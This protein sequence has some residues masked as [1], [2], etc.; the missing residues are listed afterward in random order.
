MTCYHPI[1]AIY[2]AV[3]DQDGKRRLS[4]SGFPKYDDSPIMRDYLDYSIIKGFRIHVPCGRCI[5]CRL[6][7]SRHWAIRS[8]HEAKMHD[9][10]CFVT[11]TFNNEHLPDDGSVHKSYIKSW[12][13]RF[14]YKYGE[15]IRY[16][17]CGEY[18]S[19]RM[20]PHYHIL[21]F[22]FDFPDKYIYS[23]R[24]GNIYYRSPGLEEI[25][26]DP[27]ATESNGFSIIGEVNFE[28]S[29]YVSRYITKKIFGAE[30]QKKY[31]GREPEFQ[32]M[33]RMPGL[34]YDFLQ[35]Y[36]TDMFNTGFVVIDNLSGHK[37]KAPIPRYYVDKMKDINEDV[38]NR[39]KLDRL[40]YLYDN[41][42]V[43]NI[44][45]STERLLAREELK[46]LKLDKL[47]RIYEMD[48]FVHNI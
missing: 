17:L 35:K 29:A 14:R 7:Y 34:G 36:Y 44:D 45:E 33:S 12:L 30:A 25:W 41:L 47:V 37:F 32:L 4:F 31:E 8:M 2:P 20:R 21:F 38:Y 9:K 46:N 42:C 24:R 1:T 27:H 28:T 16:L 23:V 6:D 48:D 13:K 10:N 11:L 18:G 19:K 5:G 22:G 26:R 3:P 39:Y 43:D 15:N 40:Q